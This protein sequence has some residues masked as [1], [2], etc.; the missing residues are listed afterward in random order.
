[1]TIAKTQPT[2]HPRAPKHVENSTDAARGEPLAVRAQKR[3]AEL[4]L[5]LE[6]IPVEDLRA[7][8]DIELAISSIDSHLTGDVAHLSD[9]TASELS[10]LLES[11]KHLAEFTPKSRA[12]S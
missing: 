8:N 9:A 7:R 10:R 1:M 12:R 6:K 11:V 5:A 2:K 3:K 4:A